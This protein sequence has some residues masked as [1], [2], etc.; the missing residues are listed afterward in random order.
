MKKLD[1][2]NVTIKIRKETT[3]E[4]FNI[5][6][7]NINFRLL[8]GVTGYISDYDL[9]KVIVD[10][11]YRKDRLVI[12]Y[13]NNCDNTFCYDRYKAYEEFRRNNKNDSSSKKYFELKYGIELAEEKFALKCKKCS[14]DES[15]E[16]YADW[17]EKVKSSEENFIKRHGEELGKEKWKS[18]C[19]RNKGNHTLERH[20]E[21]YG[22]EE[23]LKRFNENQIKLKNKNT[24]KYY[25]ERF[26]V[27]EGTDK[28]NAKN[29]K[30]SLSSKEFAKTV[31][32]DFYDHMSLK[33]YT[34]KYGEALGTVKCYEVRNKISN[35]FKNK[36]PEE[37]KVWLD[38][39][40]KTLEDNNKWSKLEDKGELEQYSRKV[41]AVT[42]KQDISGLKN[43]EKRGNHSYSKEA[44][45]L[46]H[47]ISIVQGFQ[48]GIPYEIVGSLENL[49]M[50]HY[51][52]NIS[53]HSRSY[54]AI[55]R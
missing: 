9:Q 21:I 42:R 30:N 27:I 22:E 4:N 2:A 14:M 24:L 5:L 50:L 28:Y 54:T 29:S 46:D 26:G 20:I 8:Y 32:K 41:W 33:F 18:F 11:I 15:K 44:Y 31:S 17:K 23:G 52:E 39:M 3:E 37:R 53:K 7:Y 49:Q 36:T 1:P 19:N 55:N 6:N 10:K 45:H 43:L 38:K 13:I 51:A 35:T 12:K 47:K 40:R 48:F 16:G 25:I 34:E